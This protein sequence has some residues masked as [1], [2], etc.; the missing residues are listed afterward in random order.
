M[1]YH[2]LLWLGELV[3]PDDQSK[4]Q[5]Q[6]LIPQRTV[7]FCTDS[8]LKGYQF[9]LPTHKADQ[10]YYGSTVL[11]QAHTPEIDPLL[12]FQKYI[13]QHDSL[14]PSIL[15][16]WVWK[17][18]LSPSWLWFLHR[19]WC[20]FPPNISGHSFWARGATRLASVGVAEE[21]IQALGHWSSDTWKAYIWK[22]PVVITSRALGHS[23]IFRDHP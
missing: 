13:Q 5:Y 14:F 7:K 10:H 21:Q 6:K 11:I 2:G 3:I 18:R 22:N 23:S 17:N 8:S 12:I 1:A 19:L 16:L 4:L 15:V 20:F 9:Q